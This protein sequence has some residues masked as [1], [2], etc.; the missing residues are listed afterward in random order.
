MTPRFFFFP[1][2]KVPFKGVKP[3]GEN[4]AKSFQ[5]RSKFSVVDPPKQSFN[6]IL[7]LVIVMNEPMNHQNKSTH[8]VLCAARRPAEVIPGA[9]PK[10]A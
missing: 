6:F 2:L 10:A 7:L 1:L 8:C 3:A 5:V 9:D 4:R